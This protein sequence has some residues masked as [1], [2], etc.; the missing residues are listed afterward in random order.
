MDSM[1][2][3]EEPLGTADQ[4]MMRGEQLRQLKVL[5]EQEETVQEEHEYDLEQDQPSDQVDQLLDGRTVLRYESY[6]QHQR[7]YDD[8]KHV[9]CS[10]I[11]FGN[12]LL[13]EQD[14]S[15][16][17][18]GLCW[19]AAIILAEH[20]V[21]QEQDLLKH[22]KQTLEL[23]AGTGVC[24]L[25][26]AS[27][28]EGCHVTMTDLPELLPL[29]QRNL[30]LNDST[31]NPNQ[32]ACFPIPPTLIRLGTASATILSWGCHKDYP[33]IPYD[34]ILGADIVASLYDPIA[35]AETI[36]DLSHA[37]SVVFISYK[38]RLK[39]PHEQFEQRFR[40]LFAKVEQ[41]NPQ[42]RNKN[43]QVWILK[44]SERHDTK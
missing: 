26:I 7:Y 2:E 41:L 6:L 12:G 5:L 38:G 40:Q 34:V 29:L 11:D 18:G 10:F 19:D 15:L 13:I 28:M 44:A 37:T 27:R 3:G 21:D 22:K 35:L 43:P 31:N 9:D 14:K 39:G 17:K 4:W 16:G 32:T 8:L 25:W 24:G 1:K 30:A 23:G 33:S 20:V 42:S 36:W